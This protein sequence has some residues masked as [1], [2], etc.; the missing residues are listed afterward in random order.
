MWRLVKERRTILQ[1]HGWCPGSW[2]LP[3]LT[4]G[5][6]GRVLNAT[7]TWSFPAD[8]D[9]IILGWSQGIGIFFKILNPYPFPGWFYQTAKVRIT[10]LLPEIRQRKEGVRQRRGG[11]KNAWNLISGALL[12]SGNLGHSNQARKNIPESNILCMCSTV[13]KTDVKWYSWRTEEVLCLRA[14]PCPE[15]CP[16]LPKKV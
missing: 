11:N 2:I 9:Q 3:I 5:C 13:N 16:S 14:R 15:R 7:E 12:G 8:S 4:F 1:A 10:V 6:T